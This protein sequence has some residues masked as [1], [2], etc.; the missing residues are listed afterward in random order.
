[1]SKLHF[2]RDFS[3]LTAGRSADYE[4]KAWYIENE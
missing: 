1:M 2:S 3:P 4:R